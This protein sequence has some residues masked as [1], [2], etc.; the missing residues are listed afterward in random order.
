MGSE[1]D[2][3]VVWEAQPHKM[4]NSCP[5]VLFVARARERQVQPRPWLSCEPK[6][7]KATETDFNRVG[8][9]VSCCV[10][11]Y[12]CP[13]EGLEDLVRARAESSKKH[14]RSQLQQVEGERGRGGRRCC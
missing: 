6:R 10:L 9:S 4:G 13:Q 7:Q 14:F 8:C 12:K 1:D 5:P 2:W 3:R 11:Y